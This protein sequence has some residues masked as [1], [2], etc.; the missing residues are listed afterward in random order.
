MYDL[1]Q[2]KYFGQ[3]V[4]YLSFNDC[5]CGMNRAHIIM[6]ENSEYT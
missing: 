6:F 1:M 5:D 2:V 4:L 3:K